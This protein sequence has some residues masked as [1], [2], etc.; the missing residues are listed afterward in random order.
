MKKIKLFTIVSMLM[1]VFIPMNIHAE[2]NEELVCYYVENCEGDL[3]L[4]CVDPN[5]PA[6][7]QIG[8]PP[9]C[10]NGD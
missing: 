7:C 2:D 3:E 1:L 4:I 8:C 10:E 6:P 9:G 5:V